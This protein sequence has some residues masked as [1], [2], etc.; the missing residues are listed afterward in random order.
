MILIKSLPSR[1]NTITLSKEISYFF[2][3]FLHKKKK[4][5]TR[6]NKKQKQTKQKQKTFFNFF[7]GDGF[8]CATGLCLLTTQRCDGYRDCPLDDRS[9]ETRC[10]GKLHIDHVF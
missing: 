10:I 1:F 5:I 8:Q 9:D 4:K 6:Q 2:K 7:T 3:R